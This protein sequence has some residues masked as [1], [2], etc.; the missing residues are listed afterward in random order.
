MTRFAVRT[1]VR[2]YRAGVNV[3]GWMPTLS[4]YLGHLK[5]KDTYWYLSATPAL[6]RQ[7]SARLEKTWG[8]L[9]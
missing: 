5:P 8:G 6:F 3:D 2:W 9:P 1:L 4:T 7:A